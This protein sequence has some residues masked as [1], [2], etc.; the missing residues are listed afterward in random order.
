MKKK[1]LSGHPARSGWAKLLR[2]MKLTTFLILAFMIDVSASVYSQNSKISIN[3]KDGTLNEILSKIEEQ[4]EY[5]FFYQNEQISDVKRKSIDVTD[6]NVL[7][8][9]SDLLEGTG[10]SYK[11][12]ERNIIIFPSPGHGEAYELHP[13]ENRGAQQ[14]RAISGKV[15][16]P[17]GSPL[18][19]V[20]VVVKGTTKGTVTDSYGNYTLLDIKDNETLIFSFVGMRAQEIPVTGKAKIDIVMEED[21]IGIEEVVAVG[22]GTMKKVNLT[23]AVVAV[24]SDEILITKS[25]NVQNALTGKVSGVRIIQKTSE[26]G[27]FSNQFDIRGFGSPL[28]V[29]DGV[30]RDNITRL[31]PNEIESVSVLKDA[32]AA[33][34]G[35]RAA[36]G[37]VLITTKRGTKG[38]AK[39]EYT[40]FYGSQK[41]IGLAK[42]VETLDRYTLMNEK[43]MHSTTN[44]TL[45]YS[46]EDFAPY[47]NGSKQG[48]D[49]Y[50][51]VMNERA[52]QHNHNLSVSG[53][54]NDD[55]I[56]Y[57]MNMGYVNQKG[58]WKSGDLNY[59]RYNLRMNVNAQ[60]CKNLKASLKI[61]GIIDEKNC[62]FA[63]NE[64]NLSSPS[65][66]TVFKALWR[67]QPN[68]EYYVNN[69]TDYL[70]RVGDHPGAMTDADVIGYQKDRSKWFQSQFELEY[71]IPFVEGLKAKGMFSYDG[72]FDDNT[73][74]KK[75]YNLY[76]YSASTD[77]YIGYT[78][79]SP[80]LLTRTYNSE[81]STLL[82]FSLNYS[83]L[84]NN[85]HNIG[86]LLLYEES[87]READNFYASREL[88]ISIDYLF[89]GETDNQVGNSN[90]DGI[91]KNANKGLVGRFNYDYNGKYIAEF[92]FR[93]D[94]SSKFPTNK[95]WG[96]FPAVQVGWRI[97]E[98][99]FF[100]DLVP[101]SILNNMK[102]RAS[103]G[104]MGDDNASSYQF[105]SGYDYP[106]N[107]TYNML[108]GNS[109]F[110]DSLVNSVGFRSSPNMNITWYESKTANIGI[111]MNFWNGLLD[112]SCDMFRRNRDGLLATRLLSIPG[113]F[114]ST[115][116]QENLNSDQTS[117]FEITLG[118]RNK[119][120]D[121]GYNILGNLS[122]TRTK[123]K[124]VE[125]GE[126]GSAYDNWRNNTNN[127]YNDIWFGLGYEGQ[128]QSY[129]Q[130]A[131]SDLYASRSTLPGDYIYE[132]WNDDGVIDELDYHP[133]ATT[134]N[135]TSDESKQNYPLMNFGLTTSFDYKGFDLNLLF[136]GGAM[137]YVAYGD[138]LLMPLLW[139]GNALETFMD[140]WH[141]TD[142][143][144]D[145][146]DPNTQWESG[147]WAYTGSY[148]EENSM[149][150]IQNGA[151]VRLKSAELGYSLPKAWMD[152]AG[153][154]RVRIFVNGYNLL[155]FTNVKG[156]DPEHPSENYS[157][158]Y[159][160]SRTVNI[161]GTITF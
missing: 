124:Y 36:N 104:I 132:D 64:G 117:G 53:S 3:V 93:Y 52:P 39:I 110:G 147:Y 136:Q 79:N 121:V 67:V 111:D 25:Q 4:S 113:T 83:H 90:I 33:V 154:Q 135:P 27:D 140:R 148:P 38:R 151:Y 115:L 1:P 29:I 161:G 60:I 2:I 98:E 85:K 129:D 77:E 131:N 45:I 119:I 92:S 10:L 114:G 24:K 89:A 58:Y 6:R 15:T 42:P 41:A 11:L 82:R 56:D 106:Y 100:Q 94:G 86:V 95:Q 143:K 46:D 149:R 65:S 71:Q 130:I 76:D 30:P 8:L 47:L 116:P 40:G 101:S 103:Y 14:P 72:T 26:P 97:T 68:Y 61:N 75:S 22:Y 21:A 159:P 145:P 54:S 70:A 155:T 44:P 152:K 87:T 102:L 17:A 128:Y 20:T 107:G 146:Y 28:V 80:D 19:G 73:N 66:W 150:A 127:R 139:D 109:K 35:V 142:P 49:W 134:T 125:C 23:G 59:K 158:M 74:Y 120:G 105:I 31:D 81:A 18:P 160:Q 34:Y 43:Y 32:S 137:S 153:L 62:P 118:H 16:D 84:F 123:N 157:C 5:R 37:V 91:W 144:A 57:F 96:F 99:S 133:I 9:I 50:D 48:T 13:Q 51:M 108:P 112:F 63:E 7:E 12:V 156:V 55:K 138:M 88:A 126:M 78:T 69:N 122:L 141:P